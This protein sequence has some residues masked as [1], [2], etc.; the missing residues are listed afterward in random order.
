VIDTI[1][2]DHT[3]FSLEAKLD[4][5]QTILDKRMGQNTIQDYPTMMFSE[6]VGKG[7]ISLEQMVAVTSTNAAKIFGMYPRK[8]VIAVGSDADIV[9]WDP[10]AEYLISAKTHHMRVD[11]SMFEGW[12]V[13]GNA[14]TVLSRGEVIVEGGAYT[15]KAGRGQYLRRAARGGAWQ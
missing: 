2:T 11:Y 7:R 6:G 1:G 13:K 10:E 4:P 12:R 15:G 3:A 8:G 14:K 9:I 5:T